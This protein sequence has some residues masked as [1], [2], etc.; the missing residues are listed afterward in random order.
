[1]EHGPYYNQLTPYTLTGAVQVLT[2]DPARTLLAVLCLVEN[3]KRLVPS[4]R[5]ALTAMRCLQP[6]ELGSPLVPFP[7]RQ[8]SLKRGS[9]GRG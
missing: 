8:A 1:M 9:P 4:P 6:T 5:S 2:I 7:C 3:P